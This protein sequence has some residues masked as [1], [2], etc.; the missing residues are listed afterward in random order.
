[1]NKP[2]KP[3]LEVRNIMNIKYIYRFDKIST[4]FLSKS[5][6]RDWEET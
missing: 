4:K 5:L 6:S 3:K 1:M 2:K